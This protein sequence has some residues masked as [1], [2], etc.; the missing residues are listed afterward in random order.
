MSYHWVLGWIEKSSQS[1]KAK[2][3]L[4]ILKVNQGSTHI[5]THGYTQ[6]KHTRVYKIGKGNFCLFMCM[7]QSKHCVWGKAY[8]AQRCL[9]SLPSTSSSLGLNHL[10]TTQCWLTG[11][12]LIISSVRLKW[13]RYTFSLNCGT[14]S[15]SLILCWRDARTRLYIP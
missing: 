11:L 2:E 4:L 8:I 7:Y 13:G 1:I 6:H 14:L 9:F 10:C 12:Y 15:P 5:E 3:K